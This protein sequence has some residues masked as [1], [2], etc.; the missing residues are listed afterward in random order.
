[1]SA[2]GV[3]LQASVRVLDS[4]QGRDGWCEEP[5]RGHN[6]QAVHGSLAAL[7]SAF[8]LAPSPSV[9]TNDT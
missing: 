9:F 1:M 5:C 2:K 8:E 4:D 6:A 7:M 3:Y